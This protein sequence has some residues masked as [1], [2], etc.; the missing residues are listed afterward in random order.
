MQE[1]LRTWASGLTDGVFG[2]NAQLA[3]I[4]LSA[5]HAAPPNV[6]GIITADS[7][8]TLAYGNKG[9]AWPQLVLLD[10]DDGEWE[11]EVGTRYRDGNVR[12]T[13]LYVPRDRDAALSYRNASYT[14]RAILRATEA[15]LGNDNAALRT[16]N[17]IYVIAAA[18]PGP[19]TGL[20]RRPRTEDIRGIPHAGGL[21]FTFRVRDLAP[22]AP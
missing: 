10:E 18:A 6:A 3:T 8:E 14:R 22:F 4:P 17:G 19:R 5:G 9:D 1:V 21:T 11:P 7:D 20:R 15:W 2:V 12:A 13:V 16:E